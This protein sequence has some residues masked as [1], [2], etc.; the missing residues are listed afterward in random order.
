MPHE[1]TDPQK[2]FRVNTSVELLALL[3]QYSEI[4]FEGIATGDELWVCYQIESESM[5]AHRREKVIPRLRPGISIEKVM[6]TVLFT[7][8][9]LTALDALS[10]GYKYDQ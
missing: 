1:L 7:V 9:Q 3:N 10:Q 8:W 2:K 4:Q 6:I 5:L